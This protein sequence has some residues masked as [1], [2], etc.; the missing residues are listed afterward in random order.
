[1]NIIWDSMRCDRGTEEDD[2]CHVLFTWILYKYDKYWTLVGHCLHDFLTSRFS[3]DNY[4]QKFYWKSLDTKV[5]KPALFFLLRKWFEPRSNIPWL[6]KIMWV[7]RVLR[8]GDWSPSQDSNHPD[9]LFQSNYYY[10]HFVGHFG[11]SYGLKWRN[12]RAK[13]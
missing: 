8:L 6:K 11:A 12:W 3:N 1:M 7:I 13:M 5:F 4:Q 2:I 10:C 9:D